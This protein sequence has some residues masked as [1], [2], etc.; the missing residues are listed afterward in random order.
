[1]YNWFTNF[2]KEDGQ[3]SYNL[4]ALPIVVDH[5][6]DDEEKAFL[7]FQ[8]G[9]SHFDDRKTVFRAKMYVAEIEGQKLL[10]TDGKEEYPNTLS[11]ELEDGMDNKAVLGQG[12]EFR[13]KLVKGKKSKVESGT[14]NWGEEENSGG[15]DPDKLVVEAVEGVIK[16]MTLGKVVKSKKAVVESDEDELPF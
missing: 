12:Y 1:M 14:A 6:I 5:A 8:N 2:E 7:N 9:A 10:L 13:L 15:Y 16:D 11:V 4:E 3:I